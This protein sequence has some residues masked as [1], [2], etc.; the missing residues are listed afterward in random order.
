LVL[1][2]DTGFDRNYQRDPYAGY[3]NDQGLYFPVTNLDPRYHPKQL[4]LGVEFD[5][6][7]MAYPYTELD[8]AGGAVDDRLGGQVYKVIYDR[9]SQTAWIEDPQGQKL[10]AITTFWFA[11]MAFHPDSSVFTAD[12]NSPQQLE[13][14]QPIL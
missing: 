10:P 2:T 4:T 1:S 3:Q 5:D 12:E 11:W 7:F 8:K 14:S 6:K 13:L 9:E